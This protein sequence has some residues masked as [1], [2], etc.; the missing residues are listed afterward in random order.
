MI[1]APKKR[2]VTTTK[3]ARAARVEPERVYVPDRAS[4]REW[5][6]RHHAI[7]PGI[8]LVFDKL[9][10]GR[11]RLAYADAVEEA[12]CL[13]WIDSTSRSLDDVQY[14]Q[15]FVPRKPKSTWSKLNKERIARLTEAGLMAPAG[16]TSV[17]TAQC[18]G[19]WTSLDEVEAFVVPSDLAAALA[20]QKNA[21][22]NFAAFS[23]SNRKM[24]LHWV[25]QAKRPETR[26]ARIA[27]VAG[28]AAKNQ[29]TR[30]DSPARKDR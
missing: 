8:M 5:L 30:Q 18:N 11:A 12:L 29:K 7:S 13:G 19:A 26:A 17:E 10:A 15:L 1:G 3:T 28:F 4:W 25:S 6:E 9:S 23:P 20:K 21:E 14:M 2:A 16:V 27:A 24:Y 22:R